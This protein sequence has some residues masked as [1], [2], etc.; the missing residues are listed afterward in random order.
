M[1][2][3]ATGRT[4]QA[5]THGR[6]EQKMLFFFLCLYVYNAIVKV[7]NHG[8]VPYCVGVTS[9]NMQSKT[10]LLSLHSTFLSCIFLQIYFHCHLSVLQTVLSLFSFMCF[11][12]DVLLPS[13]LCETHSNKLDLRGILEANYF[14]LFRDMATEMKD[15]KRLYVT[16]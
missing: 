13:F 9:L 7:I 8:I 16:K 12:N 15:R 11:L 6:R 2:N 4:H 1:L 5:D 10:V 14:Q 3:H